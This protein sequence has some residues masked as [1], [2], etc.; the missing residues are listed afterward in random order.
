MEIIYSIIGIRVIVRVR[1]QPYFPKLSYLEI[2]IFIWLL[3][4]KLPKGHK[5]VGVVYHTPI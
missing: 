1:S 5:F 4:V 3:H 2:W